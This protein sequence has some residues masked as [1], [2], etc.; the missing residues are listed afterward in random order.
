MFKLLLFNDF[1][2]LLLSSLDNFYNDKW[3]YITVNNNAPTVIWSFGFYL[4]GHQF[5]FNRPVSSKF[6]LKVFE[7]FY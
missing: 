5:R 1:D 2:S 7:I 3:D 4:F 6:I